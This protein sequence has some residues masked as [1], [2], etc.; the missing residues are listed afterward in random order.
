MQEQLQCKQKTE[1]INLS[2]P[3]LTLTQIK[4]E[5]ITIE[6]KNNRH[7]RRDISVLFIE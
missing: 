3:E 1:V 4:C 6:P 5:Y 2:V 7:G